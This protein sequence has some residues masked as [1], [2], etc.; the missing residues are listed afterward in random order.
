MNLKKGAILFLALVFAGGNCLIAQDLSLRETGITVRQAIAQIKEQ[1][2]YSFVYASSDLNVRQT[3]NLDAETLQE[4]VTQILDGQDLTYEIQ[5][6][7][8]I[9]KKIEQGG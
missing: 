7:N 3:V 8:I 2:G 1:T 4:A 9:V 6:K 5:G